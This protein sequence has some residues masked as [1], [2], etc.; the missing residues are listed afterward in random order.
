MRRIH[1]IDLVEQL[2]RDGSQEFTLYVAG[3]PV[4]GTWIPSEHQ[5]P[6]QALPQVLRCIIRDAEEG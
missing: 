5:T 4:N 6:Q 1:D 3:K 2:G